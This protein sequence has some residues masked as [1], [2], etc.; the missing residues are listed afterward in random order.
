VP[1]QVKV[2][3]IDG[4]PP[5]DA[6]NADMRTN[7]EGPV[8]IRGKLYVSEFPLTQ[9]PGSRIL[10][11]DPVNGTVSVALADS[12]SNGLAVDAHGALIATH[13]GLG[14]IV[15]LTFPLGMPEVL[16]A[17]YDGRRFDS[18]NDIAVRS[19]GT[20]YFSDP[21]YQAPNMR[22]Q[23]KTRVYRLAP[24]ASEA[25]VIDEQRSEPNGVTLSIDERTLYVAG[26]DGILAYPVMPDGT[27]G[28]GQRVAGFNGG[29][30]GMGI[31]C[32]G[33]L[34]ATSGKR[35]VVLSPAGMEIGSI[36]VDQAENV[37]NVAFGGADQKTLHHEHGLGHTAR[38]VP[39]PA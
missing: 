6:F 27:V 35:V 31:D 17:G 39:S 3:R 32:A 38:C 10:A 33:N 14:A 30:D 34:Y 2:E 26:S 8:W 15:K 28:S 25:T 9:T 11:I 29:S 16:V 36:P 7:M 19:D 24:G 21:D 13:H 37:T 4:A 12:G 5:A 1:L 18:P 20:I 23:A 22:P